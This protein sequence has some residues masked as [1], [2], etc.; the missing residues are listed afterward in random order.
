MT[1]QEY[2]YQKFGVY[3]NN[4][5]LNKYFQ[6]ALPDKPKSKCVSIKNLGESAYGRDFR[7]NVTFYWRSN[8]INKKIDSMNKFQKEQ[9][10]TKLRKQQLAEDIKQ[11]QLKL[12]FIAEEWEK[13][14]APAVKNDYFIRK[15]CKVTTDFKMKGNNVLIPGY[16][17]L[18]NKTIYT[19]Q[20]IQPDGT[21]KFL[22]N[23]QPKQS[24]YILPTHF[25]LK[26]AD[27]IFFVEGI[28]TGCSTMELVNSY[29]DTKLFSVVCCFTAH[30]IPSVVKLFRDAFPFKQMV[31]VADGDEAGRSSCK[32]AILMGANSMLDFCEDGYD[33]NDIWLFSKEL[34]LIKFEDAFEHI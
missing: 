29:S 24:F 17:T 8:S 26:D 15:Q 25:K 27:C 2:I 19:I 32:T 20:E 1:L 3:V 9:Y 14:K 30:N 21:K 13:Y 10:Y 22:Y 7:N 33:V 34:A 28:A 6:F 11:F 4:I 18:L 31:V 23:S 16:G 5:P 12:E